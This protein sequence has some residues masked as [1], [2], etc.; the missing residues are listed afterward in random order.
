MS[1]AAATATI[2]SGLAG[3][4]SSP[5]AIVAARALGRRTQPMPH[6]PPTPAAVAAREEH[7]N[8]SE[9]PTAAVRMGPARCSRSAESNLKGKKPAAP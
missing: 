7:R 5:D 2:R 6:E 8:Y 1:F 9:P 3:G 4:I